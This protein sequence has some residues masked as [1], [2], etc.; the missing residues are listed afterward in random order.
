MNLATITAG[1]SDQA[2]ASRF[3]AFLELTKPR[4]SLLVL[5]SV[6]AAGFA[7]GE[8]VNFWLI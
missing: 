1:I 2:T 3:G 4:I 7:A 5:F 6:A 8:S